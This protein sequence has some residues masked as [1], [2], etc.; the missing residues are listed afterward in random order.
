MIQVGWLDAP[1]AAKLIGLS[2]QFRR[3]TAPCDLALRQQIMPVGKGQLRGEILVDADN[4]SGANI[5]SDRDTSY[6]RD[7]LSIEQE[8]PDDCCSDVLEPKSGKV[9]L[10]LAN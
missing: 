3:R 2:A 10:V 7:A 1:L 4:G 5:W 9:E 6:N 8:N